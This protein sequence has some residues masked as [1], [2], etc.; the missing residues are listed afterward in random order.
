VPFQLYHVLCCV[1]A[2]PVRKRAEGWRLLL[3]K[4]G[5][6]SEYRR[7][8]HHF[9]AQTQ[10]F[11]FKSRAELKPDRSHSK[12]N[13][14]PLCRAALSTA[15]LQTFICYSATL[16]LDGGEPVLDKQDPIKMRICVDRLILLRGRELPDEV[17]VSQ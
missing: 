17:C 11:P 14:C 7:T 12:S 6:S 8:S 1:S 13:S 3:A 9:T 15:I 2:G 4:V 10:V 5:D 16:K